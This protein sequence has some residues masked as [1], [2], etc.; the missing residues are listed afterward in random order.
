M[1]NLL[2]DLRRS[3]EKVEAFPGAKKEN[4]VL[5][6]RKVIKCLCSGNTKDWEIL[7]L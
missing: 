5:L 3:V 7:L 4:K 2:M 6:R 1:V